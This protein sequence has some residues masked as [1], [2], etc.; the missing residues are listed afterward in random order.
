[1]GDNQRLSISKPYLRSA[2]RL[3]DRPGHISHHSLDG[4]N[5]RRSGAAHSND[6]LDTV[7][8]QTQAHKH[9]H[10][11]AV[12]STKPMYLTSQRGDFCFVDRSFIDWLL[13]VWPLKYTTDV[14]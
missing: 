14:T 6:V 8:S 3:S 10:R 5:R 4:V 7:I 12:L 1:M 9:D 11:Y 2:F 13:H